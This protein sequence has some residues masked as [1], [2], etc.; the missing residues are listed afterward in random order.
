[1]NG[2]IMSSGPAAYMMVEKPIF[3]A[4]DGR[5]EPSLVH[6]VTNSVPKATARKLPHV[7]KAAGVISKPNRLRFTE[8][9][10]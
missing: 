6:R 9:S 3:A 10:E 7:W 1:M 2:R 5:C 4:F 8:V